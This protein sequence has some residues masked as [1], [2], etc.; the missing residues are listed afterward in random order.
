MEYITPIETP[1]H[2]S[3]VSSA[4]SINTINTQLKGKI[5]LGRY[6]LNSVISRG[7]M[8]SV[9]LARDITDSKRYA[10]KILRADL[11]F[12]PKIRERFLLEYRAA[13]LLQHPSII[14]TVATG[15]TSSNELFLIMEYVDGPPLRRLINRKKGISIQQTVIIAAAIAAGLEVAHSSGIIHRDLKPENI[16][17]P[18]KNN[19]DSIIKIADFG[20]AR[21]SDT[22]RITTT[23]HVLGTPS[24]MSPEQAMGAKLDSTTDIY[25]FGIIMYEMLTG[26]LP[27]SGDSPGE[28]LTSHINSIPVPVKQMPNTEQ[29][30]EDLAN[31]VM[32]CLKKYPPHRP[33]NMSEIISTLKSCSV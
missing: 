30:T 3:V 1:I 28:L 18:R 21:I 15:E 4:I 13:S 12:D 22:P 29:V 33:Q 10:V 19:D 14:K 32:K 17:V 20:I 8:G 6:R 27:F 31:M 24:Y 2:S 23:R 26:K 11:T 25:S 5:L 7:G 9:Y 16:L